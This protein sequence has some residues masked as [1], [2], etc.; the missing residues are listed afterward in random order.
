MVS[1]EENKREGR[2]INQ[3][4]VQF[5]TVSKENGKGVHKDE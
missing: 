5:A 4:Q 2:N 1:K 3:T